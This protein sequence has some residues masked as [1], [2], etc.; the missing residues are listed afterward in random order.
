MDKDLDL[1]V[2]ED[3]RGY[4]ERPHEWVSVINGCIFGI[5]VLPSKW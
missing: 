3:R 4:G 1:V 5:P 2:L